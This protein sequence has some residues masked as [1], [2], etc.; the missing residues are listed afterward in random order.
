MRKQYSCSTYRSQ[1]F[2]V[3]GQDKTVEELLNINTA[4]DCHT[5]TELIKM[6]DIS[7]AKRLRLVNDNLNKIGGENMNSNSVKRTLHVEAVGVM[8]IQLENARSLAA[9]LLQKLMS[10]HLHSL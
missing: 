7:T 4:A 6:N 2:V 1:L 3:K 10:T 9:D 8:L 5:Y